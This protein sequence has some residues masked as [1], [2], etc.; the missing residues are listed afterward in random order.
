MY[1]VSWYSD[2][3]YE[4]NP[5]LKYKGKIVIWDWLKLCSE[6]FVSA[7]VSMSG[8]WVERFILLILYSM[9]TQCAIGNWEIFWHSRDMTTEE[10]RTSVKNHIFTICSLNHPL[11][12]KAFKTKGM[13]SSWKMFWLQKDSFFVK[14]CCN[15]QFLFL[16]FSKLHGSISNICPCLSTV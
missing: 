8:K 5:Y 6:C 3:R 13:Y 12:Q 2:F 11:S 7:D 14:W 1:P 10:R 4:T 9:H 16:Y 15:L